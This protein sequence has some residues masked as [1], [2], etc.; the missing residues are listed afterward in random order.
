MLRF[1]FSYDQRLHIN[2]AKFEGHGG[3]LSRMGSRCLLDISSV[4][5]LGFGA[6][7]A[8]LLVVQV[9]VGLEGRLSGRAV[10]GQLLSGT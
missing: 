6:V 8:L 2:V 10:G 7:G 1:Y 3:S 9:G 5:L 4:Q